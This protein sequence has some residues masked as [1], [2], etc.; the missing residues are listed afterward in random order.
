MRDSFLAVLVLCIIAFFGSMI[1]GLQYVFG[2]IIP[3]LALLVFIVGFILKVLDWAKSPVPFR[4]PTTCGQE[5]SLPWIK[6]DRLEAPSN[7]LEVAGRMFLEVFAF[8]SLFRNTKSTIVGGP[9]LTYESS[10]WLWLGA[11]TF[12]YCFLVIVLRHFRL[13]VDPASIFQYLVQMLEFGD[14]FMQVGVPRFYQTNALF[15]AALLFLFLRRVLDNKVRYISQPADYFPLFLI[16]GIAITGI[17]MRYVVRVDIITIKQLTQGLFSFSPTISGNISS[18]FFIHLF[19]VSALLVYFPFSKLM[20]M[21]GVFMS[22]TRNMA[23][24]NRMIRH[25]NPWNDPN[26]KPHAYADYEDEFREFMV[27]ADIPVEKE[28]PPEPEPEP[29][30]AEEAAASEEAADQTA[31]TPSDKE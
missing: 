22:P 6:A 2:V 17:L 19:L 25:I 15:V 27:G 3:Y 14:G 29:E 24:N 7:S 20:H 4:I 16:L 26:I 13:F 9:K 31:E 28:L 5:K 1:P 30:P 18:I 11:I 10:K 8:R 21:G 23:N 12:H